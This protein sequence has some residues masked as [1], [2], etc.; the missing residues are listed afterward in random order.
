MYARLTS[1]I[2]YNAG[3]FYSLLIA[4][5]FLNPRLTRGFC[6]TRK[7]DFH[8]KVPFLVVISLAVH[9][10]FQNRQAPPTKP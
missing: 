1:V 7:R 5:A 2:G 3:V 4:K 9:I 10:T 6:Y 8:T